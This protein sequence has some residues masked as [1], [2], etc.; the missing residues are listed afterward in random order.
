MISKII[1]SRMMKCTTVLHGG[2]CHRKSTPH[3]IENEVSEKK[4][5]Q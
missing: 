1:D 2:V 3:K 5:I 4:K